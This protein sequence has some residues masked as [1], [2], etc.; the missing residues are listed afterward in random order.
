MR[1]VLT[2]HV[3]ASDA[4]SHAALCAP[5]KLDLASPPFLR[6]RAVCTVGGCVVAKQSKTVHI[7][8]TF[9]MLIF[10]ILRGTQRQD[11]HPYILGE[12][13]QLSKT[14]SPIGICG[15][16]LSCVTLWNRST[17]Q[18]IRRVPVRIPT[19]IYRSQWKHLDA[20]VPSHRV[21]VHSTSV[22]TTSFMNFVE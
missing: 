10:N 9:E 15:I 18:V 1:P 3:R 17:R 2:A 8:S 14:D 20:P 21:E 5:H 12:G 22:P 4:L 7:Q 13:G 11:L 6:A 16:F 19:V